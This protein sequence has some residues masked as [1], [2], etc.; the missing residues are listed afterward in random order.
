M[1]NAINVSFGEVSNVLLFALI[2]YSILDNKKFDSHVL[3]FVL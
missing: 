2:Y 1:K 3:Q